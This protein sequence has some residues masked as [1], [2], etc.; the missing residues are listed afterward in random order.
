MAPAA[1]PA[2]TPAANRVERLELGNA[3]DATQ[4]VHIP[5]LQF[6]PKDTFFASVETHLADTPHT[7]TVR[8]THIDSK[9]VV[10]EESQILPQTGNQFTA[11]QLSKPDGWPLGQYKVEILLDDTLAQTRLFDVVAPAV[12]P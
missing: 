5:V 3:L 6:L 11:F 1:Q 4:R 2:P 9:Q 8:W 7:L 10:L 12:T